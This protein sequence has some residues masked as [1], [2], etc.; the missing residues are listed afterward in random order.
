[1]AENEKP[2]C[3]PEIEI[4]AEMIRAR[5]DALLD[6]TKW[7]AHFG[8]GDAEDYAE[9]VLKAALAVA[10]IGYPGHHLIAQ[11]LVFDQF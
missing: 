7:T 8:Y 9:K 6:G 5:A 11:R 10:S 1:M 2:D 3:I 4:T